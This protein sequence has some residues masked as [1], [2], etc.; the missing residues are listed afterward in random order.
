MEVLGGG[1]STTV[2]VTVLAGEFPELEPEPEPAPPGSE[3]PSM[4]TTEYVALGT[5][6][7]GGRSRRSSTGKQK[8]RPTKRGISG[9]SE[10]PRPRCILKRAGWSVVQWL[11]SFWPVVAMEYTETRGGDDHGTKLGKIIRGIKSQVV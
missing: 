10:I 6:S 8:L 4:G 1:V 3:L 9:N 2:T 11:G 5:R 7:W